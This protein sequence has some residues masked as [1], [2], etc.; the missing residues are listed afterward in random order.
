M[1]NQIGEDVHGQSESQSQA[2]TTICIGRVRCSLSLRLLVWSRVQRLLRSAWTAPPTTMP[3]TKFEPAACQRHTS[4]S[5]GRRVIV[6]RGS[7]HEP[8]SWCGARTANSMTERITRSTCDTCCGLQP[9]HVT[10]HGAARRATT[11]AHGMRLRR[12][13]RRRSNSRMPP[14]ASGGPL[15]RG[16][17]CGARPRGCCPSG[18]VVMCARWHRAARP[19]SHMFDGASA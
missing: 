9:P 1:G 15:R 10:T 5:Q 16:S 7:H 18:G 17:W 8:H 2:S 19:S 4:E 13:A 3:T 14:R 12:H 6:C 11:P